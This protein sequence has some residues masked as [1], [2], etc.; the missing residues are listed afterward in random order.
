MV[1]STGWGKLYADNEVYFG[2]PFGFLHAGAGISIVMKTIHNYS[3]YGAVVGAFAESHPLVYRIVSKLCLQAVIKQA[4]Q[5]LP[6]I[7]LGLLRPIP[8]GG[9]TLTGR[10]FPERVGLF[11]QLILYS[12]V[13]ESKY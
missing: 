9:P 8:K 3:R 1:T 13:S 11:H 4:L 12:A 10:Y 7:G 2:K 5:L 6:G